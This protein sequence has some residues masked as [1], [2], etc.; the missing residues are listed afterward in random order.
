MSRNVSEPWIKGFQEVLVTRVFGSGGCTGGGGEGV[1]CGG[2]GEQ[3]RYWERYR[4]IRLG[5]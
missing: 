1:R 4:K 2:G 3:V 5:A